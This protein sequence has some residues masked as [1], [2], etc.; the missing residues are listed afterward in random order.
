M[1]LVWRARPD[2][3]AVIVGPEPPEQIMA[4]QD[5]RRVV[6]TGFVPDVRPHL[7]RA[8]VVV[9]PLR[10]GTGMKNKLQAGL[11]MGRAMV[12][13]RI[14]CEGFDRLQDGVHALV[15]DGAADTARAVLT[16]LEDPARRHALGAAGRELIRVHYGWDTAAGVLW[17]NLRHLG[18]ATG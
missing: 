6:V 8:T 18:P 11:A 4:M 17:E 9:S 5:G 7:A 16:L 1:P 13:S 3:R 14:T 10:F 2:A 12:A 15:A